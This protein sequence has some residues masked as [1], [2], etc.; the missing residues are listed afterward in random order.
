MFDPRPT[1]LFLLCL[2]FTTQPCLCAAQ[3]GIVGN[4]RATGASTTFQDLQEMAKKQQQQGGDA[5]SAMMAEGKLQEVME[6]MKDP[7]AMEQFASLGKEFQD[8]MEQMMKMD[9][10]ELQRQIE[11][12]VKMLTNEDLVEDLVNNKDEILNSLEESGTVSAEEL[13]KFRADP[14]YFELKMR[15]SFSQMSELLGNPEYV[16]HA[17]EAMKGMRDIMANP[18]RALAGMAEALGEDLNDDV[19]VEEARLQLLKGDFG[20]LAPLKE[21]FES[22]EMQQILRD[23]VKWR[24]TVKEGYE[25][26]LAGGKDSAKEEL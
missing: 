1:G 25:E 17:T 9:P 7:A 26:M 11:E 5:S 15:E 14:A 19:K 16:A 21:V 10:A 2:C 20:E 18:G 23:P 8:A 13:A 24:E 12:S 6:A 3:F 22:D 4:R